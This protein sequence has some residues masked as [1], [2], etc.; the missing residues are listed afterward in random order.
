MCFAMNNKYS[1]EY[2]VYDGIEQ[3]SPSDA[4]LLTQA[5]TLTNNAYAP[6]SHFH[7][8]AVATLNNDAIVTGTNQ[9]NASYPVTLCAERSLLATAASLHP[10]V[11]I[12]TMAIAYHNHN[13]GTNSS[14]PIS[15]CGMCRQYLA[16]YETRV[17][18][19]IRLILGGMSGKVFIIEKA[20]M[21]L[22]LTFT[23]ED[24]K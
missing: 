9:E 5:R 20:A 22:P 17:N 24:L 1:F 11:A 7:V 10:N 21:L 4:T 16:E 23:G 8:A 15:P 3:L 14:K 13:E 19:P 2:D 6:Y 12:H 18:Q